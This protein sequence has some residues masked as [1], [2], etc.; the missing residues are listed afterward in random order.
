MTM[1]GFGM[2]W[3]ALGLEQPPQA[4]GPDAPRAEGLPRTAEG[5]GG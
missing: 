5:R 3:Y 4:D 2:Q 1:Q